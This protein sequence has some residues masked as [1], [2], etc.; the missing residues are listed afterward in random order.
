MMQCPIIPCALESHS[1]DPLACVHAIDCPAALLRPGS[2]AQWEI[3]D[4]YIKDIERQKVE[5]SLKS[6]TGKK[7]AAAS[8]EK[9]QDESSLPLMEQPS[10]AKSARILDRMVNQN[11]YEEIAMDFM[12]WEDASDAYRCAES[13]SWGVSMGHVYIAQF[14]R[15]PCCSLLAWR[16]DPRGVPPS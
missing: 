2:C 16:S 5:E 15:T 9:K 3:Y 1:T 11:M 6:K 13:V 8:T 10:M 12:Y 14:F 4:E 7:P